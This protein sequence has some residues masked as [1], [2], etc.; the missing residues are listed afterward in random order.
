MITAEYLDSIGFK[1]RSE[2]DPHRRFQMDREGTNL[3]LLAG[4]DQ[5]WAVGFENISSGGGSFSIEQA[6]EI[7]RAER[8]NG[9]EVDDGA[10]PMNHNVVFLPL[11]IND[12]DELQD[13]L[14]ALKIRL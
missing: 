4:A 7:I 9:K 6:A 8:E 14:A 2:G 3:I 10:F 13:L 5:N 12:V 1:Q 11:T